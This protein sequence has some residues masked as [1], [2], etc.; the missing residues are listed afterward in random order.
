MGA[1]SVRAILLVATVLLAACGIQ[2]DAS[3]R[4]V[5]DN[6]RS[7]VNLAGSSGSAASGA[8]RIYLAGPGD[9]RALRSVTRDA[10][11]P[12]DLIRIL[13][14]GP[15]DD[16][17][18]AQYSTFIPPNAELNSATTQGEFLLVDLN[19][20]I[21]ELTPQSLMQAI[22]QIVYTANEL[23]GIEAVK[24]TVDNERLSWPTP[25]GDTTT[26]P[27]RIYDYPNFEQTA[28]PAYPAV[29]LSP[30]G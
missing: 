15:N 25:N 17:I 2:S 18:A 30:E 14:L 3:P 11:S 24:L 5:P 1:R 10:A 23:D 4:D 19:D 27:L 9:D 26:A 22:A 21:T 7:L 28:Q 8:D 13:L 16:E 12:Q 6:E 29:P 20:A